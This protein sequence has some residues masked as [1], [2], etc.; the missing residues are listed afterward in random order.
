MSNYYCKGFLLIEHV[1]W[2]Q[3]PFAILICHHS[4]SLLLWEV[5]LLQLTC[6]IPLKEFYCWLLTSLHQASNSS[7]LGMVSGS[8]SSTSALLVCWTVGLLTWFCR[9]VR[10]SGDG[11]VNSL[12]DL[13]SP[14]KP[15]RCIPL[16]FAPIFQW[17]LQVQEREYQWFI[18]ANKICVGD[19]L[20]PLSENF[21]VQH[22]LIFIEMY[23]VGTSVQC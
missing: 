16:C 23:S 22:I 12:L 4:P 18:E 13:S 17:M 19:S 2:Y 10:Y 1:F 11:V 15:L 6:T 14:M 3:S 7:S 21:L 9:Q 20:Y 5:A 8:S